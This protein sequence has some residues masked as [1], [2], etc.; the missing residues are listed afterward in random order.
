MKRILY[1]FVFFKVKFRSSI[2]VAGDTV[3]LSSEN[4]NSKNLEF[5]YVVVSSTSWT[6][7]E[8]FSILLKALIKFDDLM[9]LRKKDSSLGRYFSI[10]MIITGKGPLQKSYMEQVADLK[11][12]NVQIKT[13]WLKMEDYP[14][15]LGSADL[16]ICLH[17]SSSGLDL[18]M[19]VVDMFGCG[20]VIILYFIF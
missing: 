9:K 1:F 10:L 14:L 13:C 17:T 4:S 3:I 12:E 11:L 6:E 18:P 20:L 15:L 16:G 8:D 7:D 2:Q 19:K 5:D